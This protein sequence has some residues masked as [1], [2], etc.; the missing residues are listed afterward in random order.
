MSARRRA[1]LGLALAALGACR[2]HRPPAPEPAPPALPTAAEREADARRAQR[3]Y[4][5]GVDAYAKGDMALA[6]SLFEQVLKLDPD[7]PGA[8]RG[9][10]RL[11][12]EQAPGER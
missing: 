3:L 11:R 12:L 1:L 10:R 5:Q 7:H 2:A 6:R 9:L 4:D 8:R